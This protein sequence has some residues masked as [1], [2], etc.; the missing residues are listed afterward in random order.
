MAKR[1]YYEVL[2]V[3]RDASAE[4]IKKAYRSLARTHH[5]DVSKAPDAQ[6]KFTEIQEA[7]GVLSDE[8]KRAQYDRL[9]HAGVGGQ[10]WRP[11]GAGASHVEFDVEDLGSV[12]DAFFGGEGR[13]SFGGFR[14]GGGRGQARARPARPRVVEHD[15]DVDFET[16]AK[17]GK[18]S[19]RLSVDGQTRSIDVTV[20]RGVSDGA[21]L[22]VKSAFGEEGG[23]RTDLIL[24]VRVAKHPL[25]RREGLDLMLDLPVTLAEAALGSKVLVPTLGSPVE[26]TVPAG[27]SS[28]TRLRLKGR[29][30]EDAKGATGDLYA[31]VKVV[32]PDPSTLDEDDREALRRIS[33]H[34]LGVRAGRGWPQ[35]GSA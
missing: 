26:L 18:R 35:V 2:G 7:Y 32:T 25:F 6:Q 5:P 34:Q 28:G 17:G 3:S 16:A 8:T 33:E 22:R 29:G 15:L 14:R 20:P 21:K 19:V 12:F 1:D 27:A 31:I 30:I 4:D 24:R 13:E 23:A 10:G 11:Q 9:G